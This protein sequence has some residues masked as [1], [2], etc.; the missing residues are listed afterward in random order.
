MLSASPL[1]LFGTLLVLL[2][3]FIITFYSLMNVQSSYFKLQQV[4]LVYL[5]HTSSGACSE[6]ESPKRTIMFLFCSERHKELSFKNL[7]TLSKY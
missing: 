3:G 5:I 7:G 2:Q 1:H 4:L 6:E